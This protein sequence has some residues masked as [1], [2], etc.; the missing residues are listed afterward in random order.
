MNNSFNQNGQ[1]GGWTP[2]PYGSGNQTYSEQYLRFAEKEE[3]KQ[4]IKK[5]GSK[6]GLAIILYI[7]IS[8]AIS[9]MIL[10]ISWVFPSISKVY[11]ETVT[12]LAFDIIITFLSI[13]I[14]F[15]IV[16]Y[17]LKK[18]KV[19]DILPFGTT[20]NKNL[21]KYLVMM[22]L[23]IMVFS[24]IG[25]NY[26]SAFFQSM[27][28]I[29]FTSSVDDMSLSGIKGTLLGVLA[30]AV[31]PAI[32]EETA[33][34]GIVMQ[35]LRKYGDKFA[36]IASSVLFACMHGNMVQ[37]P[38]TVIGGLL[39]GY[40]VIATGSLWP[41]II[42]HFI[43]NLYS[44]IVVSASDNLSENVS[45][46]I[47]FLMLAVF[48]VVGVIGVVKFVKMKYKVKLSDGEIS[49]TIKEKVSAFLVNGPMIAAM[50][51]LVFITLSNIKF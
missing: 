41:A 7:V 21:A 32:V 1:F 43:N 4:K 37:I 42:L 18:E 19:S 13:G 27:L 48:A 9:F 10:F 29:E 11:S 14:P 22:F 35:P 36:I 49:M 6:C 15:F 51:L 44:V 34:R 28:G 17:S 5:I 31:V 46:I 30:I 8:Y 3:Q 50:V 47:T 26:V 45:V 38:Y 24:A 23:P 16:H 20:H 40:L 39:L 2:P 25:I 33:I 12:S